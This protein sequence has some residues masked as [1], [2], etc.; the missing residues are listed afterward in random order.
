MPINDLIIIN[1]F[2]QYWLD[3]VL[4]CRSISHGQTTNVKYCTA[5]ANFR[6]D[7]LVVVEVV[8]CIESEVVSNMHVKVS[9]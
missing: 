3:Y 4:L 7:R 6:D 2:S 5:S 8:A 1:D 9:E